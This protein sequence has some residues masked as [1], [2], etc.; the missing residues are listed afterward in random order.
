MTS[1]ITW[2]VPRGERERERERDPG[3]SLSLAPGDGK[4]RDPGNEVATTVG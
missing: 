2:L 1:Q 4:K 3:L